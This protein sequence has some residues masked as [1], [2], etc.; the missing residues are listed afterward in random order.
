MRL[1]SENHQVCHFLTSDFVRVK[2]R[3]FNLSTDSLLPVFRPSRSA[4]LL[5]SL[6]A[7]LTY[8]DGWMNIWR[9]R[10]GSMRP[11]V[12]VAPPVWWPFFNSQLR[13]LHSHTDT[14]THT[15]TQIVEIHYRFISTNMPPTPPHQD[16]IKVK[17]IFLSILS[18]SPF[19]L[20][21]LSQRALQQP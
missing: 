12:S 1:L 7:K 19:S 4:S 5:S 20:S 3:Y 10:G 6:Y 14:H 2:C 15:H 21:S 13:P 8:I 11:G 9:E 18:L 16:I 17:F